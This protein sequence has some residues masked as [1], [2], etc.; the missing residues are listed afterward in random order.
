[1][2]IYEASTCL[3]KNIFYFYTKVNQEYLMTTTLFT[4]TSCGGRYYKEDLLAMK[5]GLTE[6]CYFTL[7]A[8][9]LSGSK[10]IDLPFDGRYYSKDNKIRYHVTNGE[11]KRMLKEIS[12]HL[13][14]NI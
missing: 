11:R 2:K 12:K 4:C 7:S 8:Y 1:M 13:D 14:G 3:H 5:K 9:I 6:S 10:C